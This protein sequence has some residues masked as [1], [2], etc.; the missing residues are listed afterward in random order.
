MMLFVAFAAYLTS[1]SQAAEGPGAWLAPTVLAAAVVDTSEKVGSAGSAQRRTRTA[2][3]VVANRVARHQQCLVRCLDGPARATDRGR[4][5]D[6]SAHSSA[7]AG[8]LLVRGGHRG[9]LGGKRGGTWFRDDLR[10]PAVS[11]LNAGAERHAHG[12][13]CGV[14]ADGGFE[15]HRHG[16]LTQRERAPGYP[17]HGPRRRSLIR[18]RGSCH[19]DRHG[20]GSNTITSSPSSPSPVSTNPNDR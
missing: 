7:A 10:V 19:L 17:E 13:G 8:V 11:R 4:L 3:R 12:S 16:A 1:V 2:R 18:L 14:R 9:C 20:F 15:C 6:R 5:G